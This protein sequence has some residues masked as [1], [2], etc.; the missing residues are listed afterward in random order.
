VHDPA[1]QASALEAKGLV[2]ELPGAIEDLEA[3]RAIWE[4]LKRPLDTAR[5][6]M[7]LARRQMQQPDGAGE[8]ALSRAVALLETVGLKHRATVAHELAGTH[9]PT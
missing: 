3:A 7:L 8:Q 9:R 2:D 1:G 6:E 5:C 4:R